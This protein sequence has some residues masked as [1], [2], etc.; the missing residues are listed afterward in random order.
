MLIPGDAR[1][2]THNG[3]RNLRKAAASEK[4]V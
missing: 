1:L 4:E 3:L 2:S